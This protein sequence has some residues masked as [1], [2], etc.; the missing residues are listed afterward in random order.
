MTMHDQV[1]KALIESHITDFPHTADE[2][3]TAILDAPS[4]QMVRRSATDEIHEDDSYGGCVSCRIIDLNG[5]WDANDDDSVT[6]TVSFPCAVVKAD[7]LA[8]AIEA[9]AALYSSAVPRQWTQ[10][11][12]ALETYQEG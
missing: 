9:C 11:M 7:R 10:A 5:P 12:L 2:L 3:A 1:S 4:M 6:T 8:K